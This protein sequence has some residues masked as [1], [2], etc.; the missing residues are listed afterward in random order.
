MSSLVGTR[1]RITIDK[2]I[3]E[4]L[5]LKPGWRVF[6]RIEGNTVVLEFRPPRHQRSL[7]GVLAGK[8]RRTFATDEELYAAIEESWEFVAQEI[9]NEEPAR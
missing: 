6:Q 3:R 5:G 1:G 8:I 4:R 2:D 9:R 7:A